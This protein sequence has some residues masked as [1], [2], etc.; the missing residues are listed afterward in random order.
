MFTTK[1][2][3]LLLMFLTFYALSSSPTLLL[4][5]EDLIPDVHGKWKITLETRRGPMNGTAMIEQDGEKIK[6]TI[7][8]NRGDQIGE[9]KVKK[10]GKIYWT[11]KR[12]TQRGIMMIRYE[13]KLKDNPIKGTMRMGRMGS[14]PFT[15]V[16][17]APESDS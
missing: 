2:T 14:A 15:A 13:G 1:R 7:P 9:G 17:M 12:R 4:A 16:R 8:T 10:D 11:I 5:D 3:T 6:V